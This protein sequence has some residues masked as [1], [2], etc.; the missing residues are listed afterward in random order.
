M[1]LTDEE[2]GH[3]TELIAQREHTNKPELLE[4]DIARFTQKCADAHGVSVDEINLE[5]GR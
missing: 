1:I 4:Q 3:L 5:I 2:R